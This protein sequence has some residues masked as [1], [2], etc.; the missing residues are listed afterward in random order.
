V[1][2]R[3]ERFRKLFAEFRSQ[4]RAMM[5]KLLRSACKCCSCSNGKRRDHGGRQKIYPDLFD[6]R[7]R[8]CFKGAK[9][10]T[11]GDGFLANCGRYLFISERSA[12]LIG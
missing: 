2:R 8:A 5:R 10:M 9:A 7:V 12:A 11:E 3:R 1:A 4:L 6:R